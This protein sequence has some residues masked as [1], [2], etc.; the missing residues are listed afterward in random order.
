MK[1]HATHAKTVKLF[2]LSTIIIIA[3]LYKILNWKKGKK[4]KSKNFYRANVL[5]VEKKRKIFFVPNK[6]VVA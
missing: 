2:F 5:F 4:C 1:N 3:K 6:R